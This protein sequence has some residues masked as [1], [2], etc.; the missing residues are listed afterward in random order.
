VAVEITAAPSRERD[1]VGVLLYDEH[2]ENFSLSVNISVDE[3]KDLIYRLEVAVRKIERRGSPDE[4]IWG[5]RHPS[6][7]EM[8]G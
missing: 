1:V 4:S 8:G 6:Y 5:H 3:A 2:H 7:D